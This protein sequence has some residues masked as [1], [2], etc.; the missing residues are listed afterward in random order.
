MSLL[1]A[2][3][4][5]TGILSGLWG[6][7]SISF[8]LL[9]WA[10][11]LGC[12]SYFASPQEGARGL[13][14]SLITNISGVI[15]AMVIIQLS[16]IFPVEIIGY[17]A[18]AVV[19]FFMCIQAKQAWLGYIPRN[20]YRLLRYLCRRWQLAVGCSFSHSRWTVWLFNEGERCC[21]TQSGRNP[22]QFNGKFYKK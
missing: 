19:A 3:A 15:W 12:T 16:S 2:I 10:G 11:F 5:T 20:L 22:P 1:F 6:W 8:G 9:T 4:L 7:L 14:S 13:A 17:L 18:T 21:I